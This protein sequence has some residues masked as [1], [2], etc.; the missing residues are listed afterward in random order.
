MNEARAGCRLR[1]AEA[2]DDP[3]E[4]A[5]LVRRARWLDPWH[6]Q[7]DDVATPLADQLQ[8]AGE[9]AFAAEDWAGAFASWTA[10]L[11]ADPSRARLRRRAERARGRMLGL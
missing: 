6:A 2:T 7:L 4:A 1:Q 5:G 10:A 8:Q 11:H 9:Q 3:V